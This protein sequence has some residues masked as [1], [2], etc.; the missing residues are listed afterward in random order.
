VVVCVVVLWCWLV[1]LARVWHLQ[2]PK[3]DWTSELPLLLVERLCWL[4]LVR[5]GGR[6][7]GGGCGSCRS[8]GWVCV[9]RLLLVHAAPAE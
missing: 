3:C 4:L 7:R 6:G 5:G 9:C 2:T 1:V 8:G